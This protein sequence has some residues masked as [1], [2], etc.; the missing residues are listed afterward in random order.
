MRTSIG[1]RRLA[2]IK[3]LYKNVHTKFLT[4]PLTGGDT[5]MR[6][7][8]LRDIDIRSNCQFRIFAKCLGIFLIVSGS[9]SDQLPSPVVGLNVNMVPGTTWPTGDPFLQRQHE[10]SVP[11]SP[12]NALDRPAGPNDARNV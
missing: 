1:P 11:V 5:A 7:Q 10:P 8:M 12:R 3:P 2:V 9:A 4:R 6:L